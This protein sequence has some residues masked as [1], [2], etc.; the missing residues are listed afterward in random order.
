MLLRKRIAPRC[1]GAESVAGCAWYGETGT[2]WVFGAV[3]K[4]PNNALGLFDCGTALPARAELEAVGSEG[5]VF[6]EGPWFCRN[7][8]IELR[9]HGA[10][11]QINLAPE[12]PYRLELEN[13]GDA[14]R[15]EGELL[16]GRDDALGQA[17]SLQSLY[18]SATSPDAAL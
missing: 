5:S 11:E 18:D 12:D 1:R 14:I 2:D 13:L 8:I 3:M 10:L 17:R 9:R 16:L 4:F 7:P 6:V 15:G